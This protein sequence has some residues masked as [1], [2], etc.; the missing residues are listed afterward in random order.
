MDYNV[1]YNK[2]CPMS[3]RGDLCKGNCC[4]WWS[5]PFQM[6]GV[7]AVMAVKTNTLEQTKPF[8]RTDHWG[9]PVDQ[10]IR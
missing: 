8:E 3:P 4:A 6:C 10:D 7:T 1:H 5:E 2:I 9:N